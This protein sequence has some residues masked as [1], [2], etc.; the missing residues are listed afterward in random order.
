MNIVLSTNRFFPYS[1]G[2]VEVLALG[3]AQAYQAWGHQVSI[4]CAEPDFALGQ[5]QVSLCEES[6]AGIPVDRVWLNPQG[7]A[8]AEWTRYNV[9]LLPLLEHVLAKR[10][11]DVLHVLTFGYLSAAILDAAASLDANMFYTAC[12]YELTCSLIELVQPDGTVCD[13]R[14]S[15]HRCLACRRPRTPQ[16]EM[17][18]H[19]VRWLPAPLLSEVVA[20]WN[21][22]VERP[23]TLFEMVELL[24]Q[25]HH[26]MRSAIARLDRIVTP[27]R[28]SREVLVRN[29]VAPDKI[30]VVP[31]GVQPEV[32]GSG[33][34]TPS[35]G[36]LRFGYIGRITPVKGVDR[37]IRAFR[38]LPSQCKATLVIYGAVSEHDRDYFRA[39]QALAKENAN[40]RFGGPLE[41]TQIAQAFTHI[42]V[43]VV[44]SV[45]HEVLGIVIQEALANK[46]PVIAADIGGIPDLV[47][48]NV[49]GWLYPAFEEQALGE[50]MY[51]C[52]VEPDRVAAARQRIG[53]PRTV[54]DEAQEL[55]ALYGALP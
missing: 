27:S 18:Y 20:L 40:I 39:C 37:L 26:I 12:G 43:L 19:T 28:W 50:T 2:G 25:R 53:P 6:V 29:G 22:Y 17:V 23:I 49:N 14:A 46:T 30:T 44:P 15:L 21:R 13:G 41:R 4:L 11:V 55:L 7:H 1:T 31:H 42:D 32:I 54:Q 9:T 38:R 33:C 47:Q 45:W 34:K 16:S 52:C 5:D 10:R 51:R 8:R 3:L 24:Q 36:T 48:H 35:A